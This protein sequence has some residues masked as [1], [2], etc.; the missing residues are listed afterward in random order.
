[1][2][3]DRNV[4]LST[5]FLDELSLK[6]IK[7]INDAINGIVK[8]ED[9]AGEREDQLTAQVRKLGNNRDQLMERVVG[10]FQEEVLA[11]HGLLLL[12][13]V[14]VIGLVFLFCRPGRG[15][16]GEST[17]GGSMVDRR[18]LNTISGESEKTNI[19]LETRR[20]SIR[21]WMFA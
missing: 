21:G 7:Q 13:E 4:T 18:S 11:R 6:Y 16:A 19:K 9:L 15:K 3:L 20:S 2:A 14:L 8:R 5:G 1:M 17:A 10:E 12:M